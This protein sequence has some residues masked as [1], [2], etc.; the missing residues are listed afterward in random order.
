M[1]TQSL[2]T[3]IGLTPQPS[4]LA[5]FAGMVARFG[6]HSKLSMDRIE[7]DSR[8]GVIRVHWNLGDALTE[9]EKTDLAAPVD[10]IML[11]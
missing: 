9:Q 3:T 2:I 5:N 1:S 10:T 11:A 7:I 6:A 4:D 8:K